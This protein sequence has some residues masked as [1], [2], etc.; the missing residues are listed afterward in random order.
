[1]NAAL[2]FLIGNSVAVCF[3]FLVV[4][5]LRWLL[6]HTPKIYAYA[7]WAAV[8]LRLLLPVSISAPVSFVPAG[9]MAL[10]EQ[11]AQ[12]L[13]LPR[14][15]AP[16][17]S[18]IP[19]ETAPASAA[20]ETRPTSASQPAAELGAFWLIGLAVIVS[21]SLLQYRRFLRRCVRGTEIQP[22]IWRCSD[23]DSPV[24]IGLVHPRILLPEGLNEIEETS[25]LLHEQ[26]HSRRKD[27]W[28]KLAAYA[29]VCVYW[30]HPLVWAAF[31]LMSQDMEMA[32][33]EAVIRRQ[34]SPGKQA[35]S[36]ALVEL[37]AASWQ[38][39]PHPLNFARGSL[40][41]RIENI[42][43]Y[44]KLPC[45]AGGLLTIGL[46]VVLIVALCSPRQQNAFDAQAKTLAEQFCSALVAQDDA[47]LRSLLPDQS[48]ADRQELLRFATPECQV[49]SEKP[50]VYRDQI[51]VQ[52]DIVIQDSTL[53]ASGD[54]TLSL[55]MR[56]QDKDLF[57][58]RVQ[59]GEAAPFDLDPADAD[60]FMPLNDIVDRLRAYIP[61][62]V[63]DGINSRTIPSSHF[64]LLA[65]YDDPQTRIANSYRYN[66]QITVDADR[67]TSLHFRD[68]G[69]DASQ[70]P[71][72]NL[73]QAQGQALAEAFAQD[74][75]KLDQNP[76]WEPA[77]IQETIGGDYDSWKAV[78]DGVT[79]TICIDREHAFV[80][81]YFSEAE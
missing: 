42:L 66:F 44:K 31:A 41:R 47:E 25:V 51:R 30:F 36:H 53:Y 24:L 56:S 33:D 18:L 71:L 65:S 10:S 34:D 64:Y 35:Y 5:I 8:F 27:P 73:T 38:R 1:M 3:V 22:G 81:Y 37:A 7:L 29:L 60:A 43:N 70:W 59:V 46:V 74:F 61:Q 58:E 28:I 52:A 2:N 57:L 80:V 15:D 4:V 69:A 39:F 32:C 76:P 13:S 9:A 14:S 77:G 72:V 17:T 48:A 75:L 63:L 62:A 68:Y 50:A 11:T 6:R 20:A 54:A 26:M 19:P 45:W 55:M 21:G 23:L 79:Y 40:R 49:W 16:R 78:Q 12:A 67:M